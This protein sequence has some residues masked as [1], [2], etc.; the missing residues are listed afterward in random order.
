VMW[1]SKKDAA[2]R[3]IEDGDTV[4]AYNDVSSFRVQVAVT[5]AVRPGQVIMYHGWVNYQ[6]PGFKHFKGVMASPL[7]P[8]ECAGG[9]YHLRP[10]STTMSPGH[11]DRDTRLEIRGDQEGVTTWEPLIM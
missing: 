10:M 1:I 4:E 5:P 7:N 3:G 9:D 6:F 2:E 8:V 11:S